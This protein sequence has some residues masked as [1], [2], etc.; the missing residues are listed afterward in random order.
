MSRKRT[1]RGRRRNPS[2]KGFL[3]WKVLGFFAG[4]LVGPAA[5]W[6][7]VRPAL[8]ATAPRPGD[9]ASEVEWGTFYGDKRRA[10]MLA[11]AACGAAAYASTFAIR[12][13]RAQAFLVGTA[14]GSAVD[15]MGAAVLGG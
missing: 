5:V 11:S 3:A 15:V 14:V 4:S 1:K 2:P 10:A 9:P 7:A 6:P 13:E 8:P 12:D